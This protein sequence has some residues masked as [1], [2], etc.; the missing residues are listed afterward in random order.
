MSEKLIWVTNTVRTD[1]K[2]V[3]G[4]KDTGRMRYVNGVEGPPQATASCTVEQL[5][6][7]QII[8]IYKREGDP[9][10]RNE[11]ISAGLPWFLSRDRQPH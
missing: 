10:F 6:E 5:T 3:Y 2:G 8:G 4:S 7:Q 9:N 11:L 1:V